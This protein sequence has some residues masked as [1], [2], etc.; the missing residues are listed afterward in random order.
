[1]NKHELNDLDLQTRELGDSDF[2]F[3]GFSVIFPGDFCQFEPVKCGEAILLF[4]WESST[5]FE[6]NLNTV[7]ILSNGDGFRLEVM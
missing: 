3:K 1:M 4:S 5:R 7:I 2:A 6:Q